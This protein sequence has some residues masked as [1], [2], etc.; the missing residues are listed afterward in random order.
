MPTP[1]L[2]PAEPPAPPADAPPADDGLDEASEESFPA[3]DPPAWSPLHPGT[4]GDHP[5]A[6]RPGAGGAG[7]PA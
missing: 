6:R 5:D 4:P 7:R 3:S 2:P 1:D